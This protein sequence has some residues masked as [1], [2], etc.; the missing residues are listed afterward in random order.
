MRGPDAAASC[1]GIM[2]HELD[3]ARLEYYGRRVLG[4]SGDLAAIHTTELTGG[5]APATVYRHDLTFR[6]TEAGEATVCVVQKRTSAYEVRVMRA[7]AAVPGLRAVPPLID[8]DT[9]PDACWFVIPFYDGRELTWED[10]VPSL[11]VESLARLHAHFGSHAGELDWL[12]RSAGQWETLFRVL[13]ALPVTLV[14]GDMHPGNVML[15]MDGRVGLLDW[16]NAR[17][18][19]PMLDLAN[20]VDVDSAPWNRYLATWA[21][22]RGESLPKDLARLGYRWAKATI[23]LM[24]LPFVVRNRPPEKALDMARQ[25]WQAVQ[26]LE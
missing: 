8:E 5:Y 25:L 14:H 11:V 4:R 6:L 22:A 2:P 21:E 10:E 9:A 13:A 20:L 19:P 24:Y 1:G 3:R 7:V 23:N 17:L 12:V 15:A 18:A 16:G 26:S